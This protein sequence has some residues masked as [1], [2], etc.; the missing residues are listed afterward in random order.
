MPYRNISDTSTNNI[1][2]GHKKFIYPKIKI[3][4]F[5]GSSRCMNVTHVSHIFY[6][7]YIPVS[8][9]TKRYFYLYQ[10]SLSPSSFSCI[11]IS[12]LSS[13][14]SLLMEIAA[15]RISRAWEVRLHFCHWYFTNSSWKNMRNAKVSGAFQFRVL[16]I[17]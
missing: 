3:H 10:F 4:R 11:N 14:N 9:I 5:R 16:N 1:F 6:Y 2:L 17:L 7:K 8:A 15:Y 12:Y 13:Q